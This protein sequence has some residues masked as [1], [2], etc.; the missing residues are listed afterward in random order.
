M[1]TNHSKWLELDYKVAIAT[2]NLDRVYKL[3]MTFKDTDTRINEI[4]QKQMGFEHKQHKENMTLQTH[5]KNLREQQDK[6]HITVKEATSYMASFAKKEDK[7]EDA[8][9]QIGRFREEIYA[10]SDNQMAKFI[11]M[12]G[13]N[14]QKV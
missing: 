6:L 11:E 7:L 9:L 2:S 14:D 3:L 4:S 1:D 5:V 13:D 12:V 8:L 10:F